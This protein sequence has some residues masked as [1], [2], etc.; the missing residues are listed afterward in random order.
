MRGASLLLAILAWLCVG[1]GV[2]A[3]RGTARLGGL[4]ACRLAAATNDLDKL[5][6]DE[7]SYAKLRTMLQS[8]AKFMAAGVLMCTPASPSAA[9]T[10]VAIDNSGITFSYPEVELGLEVSPKLVQTHAS[11][12]FL[13]STSIKGLSVGVTVDPVKISNIKQFATPQELADKV[14][15]VELSKEGVFEANVLAAS[16]SQISSSLADPTVPAFEIEYK[17]DSSRGQNHYLVKTTVIQSRLYVF[18]AQCRED[19]F[20]T[21]KKSLAEIVDSFKVK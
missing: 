18:T 11:E 6:V 16:E 17:I 13:K 7:A 4:R 2:V 19:S 20:P 5:R 21:L 12:V 14:V 3:F 1:G 15:K 8:I 10:F 9:A